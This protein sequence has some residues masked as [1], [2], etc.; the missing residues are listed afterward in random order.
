LKLVPAQLEAVA[1]LQQGNRDF[2]VFMKAIAD[3]CSE[4]NERHI[5]SPES[6]EYI[7]G[8]VF[9]FSDILETV[10]GASEKIKR[11]QQP[12]T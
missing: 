2:A 1:T 3:H 6:S 10:N 4:I 9:A 8:Q 5:K 7:R 12:K 11:L